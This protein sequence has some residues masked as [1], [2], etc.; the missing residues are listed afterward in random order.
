MKVDL[1]VQGLCVLC[2]F[3]VAKLSGL[4][5]SPF[6]L[7]IARGFFV[8]AHCALIALLFMRDRQL[9][10]AREALKKVTLNFQ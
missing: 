5:E 3:A 8:V 6:A 9:T 7:W 1:E 2:V 10:D 4:S